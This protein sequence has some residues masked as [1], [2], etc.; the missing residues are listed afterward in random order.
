MKAIRFS[1][2]ALTALV[3]AA[4]LPVETKAP[5]GQSAGY[6]ADPALLGVWK[7]H[8]EEADDTDG[9]IV[10]MKDGE[11]GM[12]AILC[13]PDGGDGWEA[14]A[15]HTAKLGGRAYMSVREQ[16]K[17]GKPV[18]DEDAKH[19]IALAYR[20]ARGKLE[21]SL[22]DEKATAAAI[23]AGK[24]KGEVESGGTGDVRIT[25]DAAAQDAFFATDEGA[26]LFSSK[27]LTMKKLD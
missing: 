10:F 3:A 22:L 18:D 5:I 20:I 1:V 16:V 7:G 15:V 27:L 6:H 11:D 26:A 24:I 21:M 14:F 19:E 13:G 12:T 9:I 8:G 23:Q 17:D 4:C 25:A 2:L